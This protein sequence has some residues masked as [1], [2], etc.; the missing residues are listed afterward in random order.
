LAL[1]NA[2]ERAEVDFV[3]PLCPVADPYARA[4]YLQHCIQNPG[5]ATF[6]YHVQHDPDRAKVILDYQL[7]FFES[8]AQMQQATKQVQ[9][10]R[11]GVPTLLIVGAADK[12]VPPQVIQNAWA[13]RTI[14]IGGA[15]HEI[16]NAFP[17]HPEQDFVPDIDRFLKTVLKEEP[18]QLQSKPPP[19]RQYVLA[20]LLLVV[21]VLLFALS[22]WLA[23]TFAPVFHSQSQEWLA[24]EQGMHRFLYQP[25]HLVIGF[26]E[27]I[28][29]GGARNRSSA[30]N[31]FLTLFARPW[32]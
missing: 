13:T 16:Q 3:I 28:W 17:T 12:N 24:F 8:L 6:P 1:A 25:F 23:T 7:Q 20:V 5:D 9:S 15:G 32:S 27:M 22:W 2:L 30:T 18:L 26:V 19:S 21:A 31:E 4:V 10:N 14:S 29:K 11:H